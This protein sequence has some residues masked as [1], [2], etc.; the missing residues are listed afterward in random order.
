MLN[1]GLDLEAKS[2]DQQE[3]IEFLSN[4]D[5][6]KLGN[7]FLVHGD[8]DQQEVFK[9]ALEDNNFTNIEIPELGQEYKLN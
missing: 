6:E 1:Y 7:I 2:G 5:R 9:K 8:F 4:L 3:M